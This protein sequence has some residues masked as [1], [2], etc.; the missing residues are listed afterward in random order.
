[1]KTE[2]GVVI[3]VGLLVSVS[4]GLIA[5][6]PN[7]IPH[8]NYMHE[9][10]Q[11]EF[12]DGC[13]TDCKKKQ[14]GE[15]GYTCVP[16]DF[17]QYICR[18]PRAI[19]YPEED[20]QIR[21]VFP[22]TY[23]EFAYV[24]ENK[25]MVEKNRLFDIV[26]V[27]LLKEESKKILVEFGFHTAD[28]VDNYFEYSTILSPGDTFVSHCLGGDSKTAHIVE[29]RDVIKMEGKMY[30]EFWGTHVTMPDELLPC[31]MPELIQHSLP[32]DL[33]LGIDFGEKNRI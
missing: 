21:T 7:E 16:L 15:R 2:Y 14:E 33:R 12:E 5:S 32:V 28:N 26:K 30:F 8:W 23:G 27:I 18:P 3:S 25:E 6:Q 31:K 9:M 4:L 19:F 17:E 11:Q 1:M 22:P 10:K 24:P 13:D 29:F 20:M